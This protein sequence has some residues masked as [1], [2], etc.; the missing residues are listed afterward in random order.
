MRKNKYTL[1]PGTLYLIVILA[2]SLFYW[3][4]WKVHPDSFIQNQELNLN[5]SQ[6]LNG[7]INEK[8]DLE[9]TGVVITS[10]STLQQQVNE[11][12]VRFISTTTEESQ[13]SSE[14]S[15]IEKAQNVTG[16]ELMKSW[17]M[18]VDKYVSQSVLDNV[19]ELQKI[20]NELEIH[21]MNSANSIEMIEKNH[22]LRIK[23]LNIE[24][25][26]SKIISSSINYA[27]EHAGNFHDPKILSIFKENE[28]KESDIRNRLIKN[29]D[30]LV[31]IRMEAFKLKEEK[32]SNLSI[33]DFI[34]YSVGIATTTTFGDIVANSKFIRLL[35]CFQLLSCIYILSITI[36]RL[37]K[38]E[39]TDR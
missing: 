4:W 12:Q 25:D 28:K 3:G 10:L 37:T 30:E 27:L 31:N 34:F 7:I 15:K 16:D 38:N 1:H 6:V 26:N 39:K 8:P 9:S 13:L 18:N 2:F 35:A 36:G 19:K 5:P 24:R 14:L 11:L 29:S 22:Q 17:N 23:I 21:E 32:S 20:K 33:P